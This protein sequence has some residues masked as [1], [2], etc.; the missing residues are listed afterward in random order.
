MTTRARKIKYLNSFGLHTFHKAVIDAFRHRGTDWLTD[1]QPEDMTSD[2]VRDWRFTQKLN[3][4][5]KRIDNA[6]Q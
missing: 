2:K 4:A 5:N 6:R 1:E 3:R